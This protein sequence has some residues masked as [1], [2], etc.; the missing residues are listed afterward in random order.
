MGPLQV[1]D[2]CLS[3]SS[4]AL[5]TRASF[6]TPEVRERGLVPLRDK[7]VSQNKSKQKKPG[8]TVHLTRLLLDGS[9]GHYREETVSGLWDSYENVYLY[10]LQKKAE[11]DVHTTQTLVC[12]SFA[13]RRIANS[14]E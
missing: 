5:I 7:S 6:P 3:T 4:N 8:L 12:P 11:K 1:M 2:Q 14:S 10:L 9:K 13:Q